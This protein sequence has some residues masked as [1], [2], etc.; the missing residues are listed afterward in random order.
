MGPQEPGIDQWTASEQ[1]EQVVE[2]LE[3]HCLRAVLRYPEPEPDQ[4]Q[5]PEHGQGR[6]GEPAGAQVQVQ[7]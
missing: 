3:F 1:S 7:D 6:V 4:G 2:A 5:E